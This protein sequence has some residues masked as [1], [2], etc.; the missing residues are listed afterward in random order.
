MLGMSRKDCLLPLAATDLLK[1]LGIHREAS[2][3]W[4]LRYSLAGSKQIKPTALNVL[5]DQGNPMSV[6]AAKL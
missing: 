1:L 2:W 4:N 5:Q 6:R 3:R